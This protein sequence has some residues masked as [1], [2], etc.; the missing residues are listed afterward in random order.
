MISD[1]LL[2]V[3]KEYY[4]VNMRFESIKYQNSPEYK[5]LKSLKESAIKNRTL[6]SLIVSEL[7]KIFR[8]FEIIDFTSTEIEHFDDYEFKVLLH[9]GQPILDHDVEMIKFLVV[10]M[11]ELWI[12]VSIYAHVFCAALYTTKI[13]FSNDEWTYYSDEHVRKS[14]VVKKGLNRVEEFFKKIGYNRLGKDILSEIIPN[15]ETELKK[16]GEVTVFDCLFSDLHQ[17]IYQMLL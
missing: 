6:N 4:P 10:T 9:S 3:I 1:Y 7:S 13:D 15:I 5:R 8:E 11:H 2:K 16:E 14:E 17:H 12:Y